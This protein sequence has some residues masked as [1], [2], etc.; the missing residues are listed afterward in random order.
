MPARGRGGADLDLNLNGKQMNYTRF[1]L[2]AP[3]LPGR[4]YSYDLDQDLDSDLDR[5]A[6]G[7]EEGSA[8]LDG[9]ADHYFGHDG[10]DRSLLPPPSFLISPSTPRHPPPHILARSNASY[11][12][13]CL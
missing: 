13:G 11:V 4:R 7:Q 2:Y 10:Y 9:A 5:D 8:G 6:R 1:S 12:C 3:L